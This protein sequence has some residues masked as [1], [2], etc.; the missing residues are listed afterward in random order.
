MEKEI[1]VNIKF[2]D[3]ELA[4]FI[5]DRVVSLDDNEDYE[6]ISYFPSI[7]E[8]SFRV[9]TKEDKLNEEPECTT[10]HQCN[11]DIKDQN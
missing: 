4:K 7:G 2:A 11:M 8:F 10:H 5:G 9:F 1:T 3:N 6:V